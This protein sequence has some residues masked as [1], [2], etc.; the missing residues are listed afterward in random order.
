MASGY[1]DVNN[2]NQVGSV[3]KLSVL[4]GQP[5]TWLFMYSGLAKIEQV[6]QDGDPFSGGQSFS[7]TVYIILDNISGVL[8]GSAATSSLAGIS[9]SDLG[10]MAVESV[11]LGLRENGDLVLTTKLYSFTSGLNWNDLDTYSYYVSAKILLDEASISG[12]IRWKKTLA[13]ALT[14]P[15]FV[16]TANSQIPGSGSQSLGSDEVEATGLEDALDS[17]DDTY[18]YVPYAITGSLFGK[19]VFVVIKPI[20][21]AF[22]GAP[23]FGQLITTQ[24]SGPNMINLTNTN[25]HATDVNFEMIFQQAPR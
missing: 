25:R 16:I 3:Q 17:S 4:T 10:Q 1:L 15:N 9:G 22:S 19:S 18:Y 24:I 23:T 8:L 14:P 13:T 6:N 12:T 11:S 20:P 5:D 7:P 21:D 2:P